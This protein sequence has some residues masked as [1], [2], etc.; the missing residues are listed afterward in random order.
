[1]NWNYRRFFLLLAA[2][3]MGAFIQPDTRRV[4]IETESSESLE[5]RTNWS[6]RLLLVSLPSLLVCIPSFIMI[7]Y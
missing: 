4:D 6:T 2:L 3:F 1:M 5:R 7:Y